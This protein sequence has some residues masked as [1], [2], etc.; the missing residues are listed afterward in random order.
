[1]WL[2]FVAIICLVLLFFSALGQTWWW[3]GP[4]GNLWYGGAMLSWGLFFLALYVV[5][6]TLARMHS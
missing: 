2:P 6:P 5:W 3:R 4:Q 1:M